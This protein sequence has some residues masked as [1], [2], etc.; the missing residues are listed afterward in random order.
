MSKVI[1]VAGAGGQIGQHIVNRLVLEGNRIIFTDI[2]DGP[3]KKYIERNGENNNLVFKQMDV[4]L[5]EEIIKTLNEA[6]N[7]YG[8]VDAFINASYPRG[9]NYGLKL[10][11]VSFEDFVE[12]CSS[13][14][15]GNFLTMKK[16]GEYFKFNGGGKLI[17]FSSIYGVIAP[18]FEIYKDT[19]M[20]MPVEY[21]AIKSGLIHL[22]RYFAKYYAK[23]NV[24]FNCVS[25]G[26]INSNQP[27]SF[28]DNYSKLCPKGDLLD[29]SNLTGL[30]S[31]LISDDANS[32]NGE[33]IVIDGGFSL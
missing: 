9:R 5:E 17:L 3:Y 18:R 16:F 6:E 13:H 14:L 31:F 27:L 21:S 22:V 19:D 20:T 7:I 11:D 25:P 10:D 33:N 30:V 15:G 12:N 32:I 29:A 23:T 4:C 28:K 8:K 24:T 1:I 2:S 26:G